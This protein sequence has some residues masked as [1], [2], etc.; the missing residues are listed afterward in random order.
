MIYS[1]YTGETV[2]MPLDRAQY[3]EL[4]GRLKAEERAAVS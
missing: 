2:E 4:L 1:S 3:G